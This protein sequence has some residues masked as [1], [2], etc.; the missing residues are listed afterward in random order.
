MRLR[1]GAQRFYEGF[2]GFSFPLSFSGIAD[3][4]E[5]YDDDIPE[6]LHPSS[7]SQS[8]VGLALRLS[9]KVLRP[10]GFATSLPP[11]TSCFPSGSSAASD[12]RIIQPLAKI[13]SPQSRKM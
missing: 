3:V 1:S 11:R 2:V 4:R 13:A 10:S 7:R 9:R 12:T 5:W 6:V 8:N